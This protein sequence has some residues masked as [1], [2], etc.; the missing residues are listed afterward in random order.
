QATLASYKSKTETL[1]KRVESLEEM[2]RS[3]HDQKTRYLRSSQSVRT[4][5]DEASHLA[6]DLDHSLDSIEASLS[7]L[8]DRA[9]RLKSSLEE[10]GSEAE[11]AAPLS[12]TSSSFAPPPEPEA[13]TAA[14]VLSQADWSAPEAAP[15][16][17]PEAAPEP[18]PQLEA[19]ALEEVPAEEPAFTPVTKTQVKP[20]P[21]EQAEPELIEE[22][23]PSFVGRTE[24]PSGVFPAAV[25]PPAP[26]RAEAAADQDETAD[27]PLISPPEDEKPAEPPPSA[28]KE[29]TKRKFSWQ[30]K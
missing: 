26:A 2:R 13:E 24:A 20:R 6:G 10:T 5:V 15:A 28:K 3:E 16:P 4:R 23:P 18:E 14:P 1:Q 30:R 11:A 21:P 12:A 8:R 7:A 19:G 25:E 22:A 17:E 27:L 9:K 29:E